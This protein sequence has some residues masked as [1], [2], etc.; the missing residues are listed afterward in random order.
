VKLDRGAIGVPQS[1]S[2][3]CLIVESLIEYASLA[4][5]RQGSRSEWP[6]IDRPEFL[7]LALLAD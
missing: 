2:H 7:V 1:L 5:S 3:F 6:G 4:Q